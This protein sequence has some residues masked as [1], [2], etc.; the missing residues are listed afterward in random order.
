MIQEI[1]EKS[2]QLFQVKLILLVNLNLNKI[3]KFNLDLSSSL[4][5]TNKEILSNESYFFI[6]SNKL[7]ITRLT[8]EDL[9][10]DEKQIYAMG[11]QPI[12]VRQFYQ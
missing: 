3:I 10:K 1:K 4:N 8:L 5:K 9:N 12:S 7:E 6:P 2:I 11:Q